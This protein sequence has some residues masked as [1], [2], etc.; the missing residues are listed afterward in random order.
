MRRALVPVAS[1]CS[2]TQVIGCPLSCLP[3]RSLV[4]R[5]ERRRSSSSLLRERSL[6]SYGPA[7]SRRSPLSRTRAP[8]F[9]PIFL[10]FSRS[11]YSP[12]PALWSARSPFLLVPLAP[13]RHPHRFKRDPSAVLSLHHVLSSYASPAHNIHFHHLSCRPA[14]RF[15]IRLGGGVQR[16]PRPAPRSRFSFSASF[17]QRMLF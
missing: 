2:P 13:S 16:L 15:T 14:R 1:L 10:V 12:F 11:L 17:A 6:P 3:L 5:R 4:P 8:P 7:P 9:L